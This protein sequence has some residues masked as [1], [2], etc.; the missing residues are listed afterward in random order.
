MNDQPWNFLLQTTVCKTK[1]RE[2]KGDLRF[3]NGTASSAARRY[4]N[5]NVSFGSSLTQ[6]MYRTVAR[7]SQPSSTW[8]PQHSS[9]LA[10][11]GSSSSWMTR[12]SITYTSWPT[13]PVKASVII[14]G[15]A[16]NAQLTVLAQM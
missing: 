5:M 12:C 7:S 4:F 6:I 15:I 13:P 16:I 14:R 9:T 1:K 3:Y 11:D 8:P 10:V 2:E